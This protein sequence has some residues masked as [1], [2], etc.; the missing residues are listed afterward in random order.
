MLFRSSKKNAQFEERNTSRV[1][2]WCNQYDALRLQ[3]SRVQ[4][5]DDDEGSKRVGEVPEAGE[6][7]LDIVERLANQ[8]SRF[9]PSR[10]LGAPGWSVVASRMTSA[11]RCMSEVPG[12]GGTR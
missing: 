6:Q 5:N 4:I 10:R 7:R 2:Q 12:R 9:V 8:L 1:L 11:W 3:L